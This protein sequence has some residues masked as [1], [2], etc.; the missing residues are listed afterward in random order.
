MRVQCRTREHNA[1]PGLINRVYCQNASI[2]NSTEDAR[3]ALEETC[4]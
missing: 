3:N 4:P 2:R 1:M